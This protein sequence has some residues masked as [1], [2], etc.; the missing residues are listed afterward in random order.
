[1]QCL[2][3]LELPNNRFTRF[4]IELHRMKGLKRL[5][6]ANNSLALLPRKIDVMTNLEVL[7]LSR[8]E[9]QSYYSGVSFYQCT[10]IP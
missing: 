8:Y 7:D 2:Q 4:P 1:M 3:V 6:L 10:V 5:N 9:S